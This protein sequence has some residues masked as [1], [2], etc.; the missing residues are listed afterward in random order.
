MRSLLPALAAAPLL[1]AA[2]SYEYSNP[3]EQLAR[4]EATGRLMADLSGT[5]QLSPVEGAT[6]TLKGSANVQTT[7]DSGR[8]FV[9]GLV[10][11]RH[12]LLFEK[13]TWALQRDVQI[14]YDSEGQLE[15]VELGDV[16]LRYAV[17]LGGSFTPPGGY[18][19]D[20]WP[21]TPP[22]AVA[23]DEATGVQATVTPEGDGWTTPYTGRFFYTVPVAPVG[24]HRIRF[25]ITAEY[26]GLR[27]TWVGGPIAQDV[28]VSSEG[29][30]LTLAPTALR[31]PDTV[32]PGKLRFRVG[33]PLGVPAFTVRV[34]TVPATTEQTP[35]PDSTG[36]VEL[37]LVEGAYTIFLDLGAT[38]GTF[39]APATVTAVVVAGQTTELGTLYLLDSTVIDQ[40]S[41]TCLTS[42]DCFE[43]YSCVDR[44]CV[45]KE[46]TFQACFTGDF[47]S[48][49]SIAQ[50]TCLASGVA[51]Q[52]RSGT[53]LC[54]LAPD[55]SFTCVPLGQP[56]CLWNGTDP[57]PAICFIPP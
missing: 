16:R 37:D 39:V 14:G 49:C 44:Q 29:Q 4:G 33:A 15:G 51:T 7:R 54:G 56:D 57:V 46:P 21:F 13:G 6:V 26:G 18:A 25:A 35:T 19:I 9:T 11:G 55:S 50:S 42:A 53:G 28:P 10:A 52:C 41:Y 45:F 36:W 27:T 38:A 23:F 32:T 48:E 43:M 17:S 8:F 5:G 2:C 20:P 24:P 3:A 34:N 40:A 47:S 22:A 12:T 30:S 31:L 1:L